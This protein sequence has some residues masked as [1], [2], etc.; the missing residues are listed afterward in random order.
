MYLNQEVSLS[1]IAPPCWA[2]MWQGWGGGGGRMCVWGRGVKAEEAWYC[3][4]GKGRNIWPGQF[5]LR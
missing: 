2:G 5:G 4:L 3:V 1:C